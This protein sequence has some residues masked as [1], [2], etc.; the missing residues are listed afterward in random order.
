MYKGFYPLFFAAALAN[1]AQPSQPLPRHE[2]M[3]ASAGLSNNPAPQVIPAPDPRYM[4]YLKKASAEIVK[5]NFGEISPVINLGDGVALR[6][7]NRPR[8]SCVD[9]PVFRHTEGKMGTVIFC[10]PSIKPA[11]LKMYFVY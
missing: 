10:G 8:S 9:F 1:C 7:P 4:A 5:Q 11:G 3:I 2:N 6:L